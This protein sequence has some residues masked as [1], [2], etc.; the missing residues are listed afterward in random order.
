M[1]VVGHAWDTTGATVDVSLSEPNQTELT[2]G[3]FGVPVVTSSAVPYGFAF[4]SSYNADP[5]FWVDDPRLFVGLPP[6]AISQFSLAQ[7]AFRLQWNS[8][9]DAVYFIDTSSSLSGGWNLGTF[10]PIA[11][12]GANTGYTNSVSGDR[13]LYRVRKQ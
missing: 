9:P 5:G 3:I 2:R 4:S 8:E 12:Q 13:L 7:G 10:G 11:S 1:R 6:F